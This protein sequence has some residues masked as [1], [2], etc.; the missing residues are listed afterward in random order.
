MLKALGDKVPKVVAAALD[1]L[2]AMVT[3]YGTKVVSPKPILQGL[4]AVFAASQAPVR[5]GAKALTVRWRRSVS[6][7]LY[8]TYCSVWYCAVRNVLQR[9][10]RLVNASLPVG[11]I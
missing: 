10:I 3:A 8:R 1:V 11:P 2:R 7:L 9:T 5:E 4:P 6:A